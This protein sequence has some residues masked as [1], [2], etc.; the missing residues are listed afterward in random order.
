MLANEAERRKRE[1][2]KL[3]HS[4]AEV[5]TIRDKALL[6]KYEQRDEVKWMNQL[7]LHSKVNTIRDAQI[8]Q[9]K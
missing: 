3:N 9:K 2:E 7:I 1:I 4:G 5:D 6:A 8:R